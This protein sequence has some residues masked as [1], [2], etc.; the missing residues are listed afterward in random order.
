MKAFNRVHPQPGAD[1]AS[2]AS[3]DDEVVDLPRYRT[4]VEAVTFVACADDL[5]AT[6]MKPD[7]LTRCLDALFEFHRA[8]RIASNTP[9][10]ELTYA[11]LFPLVL[12]FRR[13]L[14]DDVVTPDGTIHLS[15]NLKFG[16]LAEHLG[17]V[18]LALVAEG[19]ARLRFGDPVLNFVERKIDAQYELSVKGKHANAVIQLAIACEVVLDGLLGLALWEEGVSD[20]DAAAVFSSDITPRL[21]SE[22]GSRFGGNWSLDTGILSSWFED[23]AGMRNRIVHAGYQPTAAEAKRADAVVVTLAERISDRL[24]DKFRRYPRTAWLFLGQAG[25]ERRSRYSNRVKTWIDGQPANAVLDWLR[26][27]SKWRDSVDAQVQR[28]RRSSP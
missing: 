8:Y 16:P 14:S 15:D 12:T 3:L 5:I 10:D 25:F 26:D 24:C 2:L 18:D 9:T 27:Y 28:R 22:C 4:I 1:T 13:A 23:V 21:K 20:T 6:E 17:S 7:P 19:V 11:Q